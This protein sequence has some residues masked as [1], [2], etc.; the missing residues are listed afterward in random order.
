M[1]PA[2]KIV[3]YPLINTLTYDAMIDIHINTETVDI[4]AILKMK[5]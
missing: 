4:D 1:I 3:N 5:K 2:N